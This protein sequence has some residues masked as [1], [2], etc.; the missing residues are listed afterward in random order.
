LRHTPTQKKRTAEVAVA[1]DHLPLRYMIVFIRS[2]P[3]PIKP[4]LS[5]KGYRADEVKMHQAWSKAIVRLAAPGSEPHGK[6]GFL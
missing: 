3:A 2:M 1:A 5:R 4:F 6:E